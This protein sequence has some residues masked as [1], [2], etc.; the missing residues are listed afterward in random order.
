MF[1]R[2]ASRII[3][4][5]VPDIN[6]MKS[7]HICSFAHQCLYGTVCETYQSYF[8]LKEQKRVTRNFSAVVVPRFKLE[9]ARCSFYVQGALVFNELPK[10]SQKKRDLSKFKSS[11]RKL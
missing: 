2:R 4:K 6:Q 1:G 9:S 3:G 10:E 8:E 7:R 11:L 5:E